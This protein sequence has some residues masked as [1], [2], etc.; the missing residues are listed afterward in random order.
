[1]KIQISHEN[2]ESIEGFELVETKYGLT[3]LEGIVDHSSEEIYIVDCIDKMNYDEATKLLTVA[4][5]KLRLN[6]KLVVNGTDLNACCQSVN[7]G[8]LNSKQFSQLIE[9]T[10]SLR[11][12]K[13]VEN[14]L[15]SFGLVIDTFALKGYTYDIK[16]IRQHN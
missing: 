6:G 16:T 15:R 12:G 8:Q 14:I 9:Q 4:V 2:T 1:M 3:Q 7:N 11:T 10:A 13:E 5:Q